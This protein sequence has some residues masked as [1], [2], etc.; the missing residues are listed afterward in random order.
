[1]TEE[2]YAAILTSASAM[3]VKECFII[4]TCNRTEIYG[5]ARDST[6][7]TNLLCSQT[8]GSI[9]DFNSMAYIKN[10]NEAIRHFFDV[11]A[12]LDSQ[13]LGDYEIVG[14]LKKAVSIAR[15]AGSMG[16]FLD[17]LS[18]MVFQCSK[19][20]KNN[21]QLSCGTVS[22]SFAAVQYIKEHVKDISSKK[23]TLVGTGKF[24]RNTCKNLVDYLDTQNITL[25]N[26]TEFKAEALASELGL[27]WASIDM[28][29]KIV[30]ESDILLVATNSPV[31]IIRKAQLENS[32]SKIIIDL[33][34]PH[35]VESEVRL[36]A[37]IT[38]V[39]V[40][41]LSKLKDRTL[42]AREAE[43]PGVLEII[44][45]YVAD[46][47]EWHTMRKYVPAMMAVKHKL[48]EIQNSGRTISLS[49]NELTLHKDKTD[50]R[51]QQVLNGMFSKMRQQNQQGCQYIEAINEFIA[52]GAK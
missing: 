39:N 21:T 50:A 28:L 34:I 14:Q 24:G 49:A 7:L 46:F 22:V 18:N 13:I 8:E 38:L 42:L 51:I 43:V 31:P 17:R 45:R 5:V 19:F 29:D 1:M 37:G 6:T 36:L 16:A 15:K 25:V 26:R 3:G 40:D 52:T 12:G 41:D 32:S 11:A 47:K 2:K 9:E 30:E 4:S 27:K 10:G 35:N 23:I 33:S 48:S 20:I 44:N